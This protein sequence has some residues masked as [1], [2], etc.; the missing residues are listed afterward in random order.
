MGCNGALV[1]REFPR[2]TE[3]R[4][5][6]VDVLGMCKSQIGSRNNGKYYQKCS[7]CTEEHNVLTATNPD[8]EVPLLL[9]DL[10]GQDPQVPWEEQDAWVSKLDI[11]PQGAR[12]ARPAPTSRPPTLSIAAALSRPPT[13][14]AATPRTSGSAGSDPPGLTRNVPTDPQVM[15]A[16]AELNLN[17]A[18]LI[19]KVADLSTKAEY[20]SSTVSRVLAYQD[21]QNGSAQSLSSAVA[22][23][24]SKIEDISQKYLFTQAYIDVNKTAIN[25]LDKNIATRLEQILAYVTARCN[26]VESQ[27]EHL[28]EEIQSSKRLYKTTL[29]EAMAKQTMLQNGVYDAIT[30]Q[31]IKL[32]R[33]FYDFKR[34]IYETIREQNAKV[35]GFLFDVAESLRTFADKP[36]ADNETKE[37]KETKAKEETNEIEEKTDSTTTIGTPMAVASAQPERYETSGDN[38]SSTDSNEPFVLEGPAQLLELVPVQLLELALAQPST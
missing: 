1:Y 19:T 38:A 16:L 24:E 17:V 7:W 6:L 13:P 34:E 3:A 18:V 23:L 11:A 28:W 14:A 2:Y 33:F 12:K 22:K 37:T 10:V 15:T 25:D 20:S 27:L 4:P 9:A 31:N 26:N 32:D 21:S 36:I 8:A 30:E 29:A 35:E 5:V